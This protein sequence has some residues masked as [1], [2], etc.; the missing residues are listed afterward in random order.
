M[1]K[2]L[3]ATAAGK[4]GYRKKL[5][6]YSAVCG[7]AVS[8]IFHVPYILHI[9]QKYGTQGLSAPLQSM[10]DF[11]QSSPV[12]SVGTEIAVLFLVRTVSAAVTAVLM[13][14][15]SGC[16]KSQVTAYI[17]NISVFVLPAALALLGVSAMRYIGVN[18]ILSYNPLAELWR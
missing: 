5:L 1:V 9:L 14:L 10:T 12:R 4:R 7:I 6:I 2:I 17:A 18:P 15:L 3:Y 8:L 11:S 16:C 13:S